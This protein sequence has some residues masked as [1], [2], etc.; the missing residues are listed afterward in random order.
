MRSSSV[1]IALLLLVAA[2]TA[3]AQPFPEPPTDGAAA[4]ASGLKRVAAGELKAAFVGMR[5]ERNS[6]GESYLAHYR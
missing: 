1:S 3:G 6:R 4:E 2:V 5:E